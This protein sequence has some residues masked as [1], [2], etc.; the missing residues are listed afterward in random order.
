MKNQAWGIQAGKAKKPSHAASRRIECFMGIGALG[1]T[2]CL[3]GKI[4]FSGVV[5][6]RPLNH[7][8]GVYA[9][10]DRL[11]LTAWFFPVG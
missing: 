4:A 3:L 11:G 2:V 5:M 10:V 8:L 1:G 6:C 9:D 7:K